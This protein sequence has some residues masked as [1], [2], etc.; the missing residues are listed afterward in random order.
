MV[1]SVLRVCVGDREAGVRADAFDLALDEQLVVDAARLVFVE[2]VFVG[3]VEPFEREVF[4]APCIGSIQK[5]AMMSGLSRRHAQCI[6][7]SPTLTLGI[8]DTGILDAKLS[9]KR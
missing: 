2:A 6:G 4:A 7:K 5:R 9:D 3:F 8:G 1:G